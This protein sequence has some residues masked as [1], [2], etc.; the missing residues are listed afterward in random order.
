MNWHADQ[1]ELLAKAENYVVE[2]LKE[3]NVFTLFALVMQPS[4]EWS[5]VHPNDEFPTPQ[6]A[7]LKVSETLRGMA[8]AGQITASLICMPVS[9]EK[10]VLGVVADMEHQASPPVVAILRYKK[11]LLSGWSLKSKEFAPGQS[12][13]FVS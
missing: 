8:G 11:G 3:R 13:V 1:R 7:L 6:A 2:F 12:R 10:G 4:G 5:V 9:Q